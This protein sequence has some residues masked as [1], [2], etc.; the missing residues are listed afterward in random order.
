MKIG[1]GS[2]KGETMK[3]NPDDRSDNAERIQRNINFTIK[4]MEAS[5][6]MIEETPDEKTKKALADK[7]ERR[8]RALEGMRHEMKDETKDRK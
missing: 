2:Y 8:R 6:D 4:N 1:K 3:H 7:N 5:E